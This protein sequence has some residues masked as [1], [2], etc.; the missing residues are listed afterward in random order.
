MLKIG[1][2]HFEGDAS[3]KVDVCDRQYVF[4]AQAP[5]HSPTSLVFN[6]TGKCPAFVVNPKIAGPAAEKQVRSK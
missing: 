4:D 5:P 2:D 3:P 1:N 6:P